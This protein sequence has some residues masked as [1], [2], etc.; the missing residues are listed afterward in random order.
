MNPRRDEP[1]EWRLARIAERMEHRVER[2]GLEQELAAA[3]VAQFV[4]PE[5]AA[6]IA[7]TVVR[8]CP[9]EAVARYELHDQ[10]WSV[11]RDLGVAPKAAAAVVIAFCGEFAV[12]QVPLIL[13]D[14][15]GEVVNRIGEEDGPWTPPPP[16]PMPPRL[17]LRMPRKPRE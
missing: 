3:L 17:P 4:R 15:D 7:R 10:L 11:L 8:R 1:R 6:G 14:E 2:F 12:R 5:R 16:P 13:R 9:F